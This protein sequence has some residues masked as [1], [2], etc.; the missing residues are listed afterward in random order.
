MVYSLLLVIVLAGLYTLLGGALRSW[1]AQENMVEVQENARLAV[2][3]ITSNLR[4]AK[5]IIDTSTYDSNSTRVYFWVDGGVIGTIEAGEIKVFNWVAGSTKRLYYGVE[6][7]PNSAPLADYVTNFSITYYNGTTQLTSGVESANRAT[8]SLT[9]SKGN[10]TRN[11][12]SSVS[13]RSKLI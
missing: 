11:Y 13:L 2:E 7:N 4:G 8:I 6:A 9:V 5:A 12:L 3:R 1:E 10:F